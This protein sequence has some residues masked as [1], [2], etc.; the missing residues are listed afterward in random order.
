MNHYSSVIVTEQKLYLK[1]MSLEEINSGKIYGRFGSGKK[2]LKN[3][4]QHAIA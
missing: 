4:P 1:L 2:G 3:F